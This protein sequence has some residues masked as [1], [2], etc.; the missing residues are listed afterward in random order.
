[1]D[2]AKRLLVVVGIASLAGTV[3]ALLAPK[4][5][6]ALV[7]TLVQVVNTTAQPVPT[8]P[9]QAFNSF[10]SNGICQF[11]DTDNGHN[12]FCLVDPIYTVPAGKIAVVEHASGRCILDS[13]IGLRE[14]R[15]KNGPGG[16]LDTLATQFSFL[17]PG[18]PM[19]FLGQNSI[20]SFAQETKTYVAAGSPIDFEMF[21]TGN[22]ANNGFDSCEVDIS[23][24][25]VSQ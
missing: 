12:D 25:L 11:I 15:V 13:G 22:Q 21:A 2:F 18:A 10:D 8:L 17:V 20:V 9:A 1:M 7:A 19:N 23:G 4:T 14:V 16:G 5:A 24:Y 6:H 3:G